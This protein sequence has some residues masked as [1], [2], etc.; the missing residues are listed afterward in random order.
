MGLD[1]PSVLNYYRFKYFSS[2]NNDMFIT[3][4]AD[5]EGAFTGDLASS[6][7]LR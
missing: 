6:S 7:N 4:Y 5:I 2:S 1:K 3:A